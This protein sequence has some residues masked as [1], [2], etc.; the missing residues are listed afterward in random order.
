MAGL[1]KCPLDK[2]LSIGVQGGELA[3]LSGNVWLTRSADPADH[4]MRSGDRIRIEPRQQV[5]VEPWDRSEW[6][7]LKWQPDPHER[8]DHSAGRGLRT[9]A[10]LGLAWFAFGAASALRRAEA[11]FDTLARRAASNAS[12]AQPCI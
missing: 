1:S 4:V 6:P 7:T 10:L 8:L 11:G 3:V 2:P 5:V 12:R 9:A